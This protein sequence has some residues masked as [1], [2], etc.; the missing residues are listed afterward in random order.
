MQNFESFAQHTTDINEFK[1]E[2]TGKNYFLKI[3]FFRFFKTIVFSIDN[4]L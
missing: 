3:R 4:P 2:K 1:V